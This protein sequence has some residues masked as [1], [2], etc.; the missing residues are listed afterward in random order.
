MGWQISKAKSLQSL[1]KNKNW[2]HI[3]G[4]PV[5]FKSIRWEATTGPQLPCLL[6]NRRSLK[7][8]I[9][10]NTYDETSTSSQNF[11]AY[12]SVYCIQFARRPVLQEMVSTA[13]TL[14]TLS[15][16]GRKHNSEVL[17]NLCLPEIPS[18]LHINFICI[19]CTFYFQCDSALPCTCPSFKPCQCCLNQALL[20]SQ[21]LRLQK[22]QNL[23][24]SNVWNSLMKGV[25]WS[26]GDAAKS[27][28]IK[29]S[30]Q[31]RAH[32]I[33]FTT[34]IFANEWSALPWS[35]WNELWVNP[36]M[37]ASPWKGTKLIYFYLGLSL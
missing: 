23:L 20:T 1:K 14:M 5:L 26:V 8:F 18:H 7:S 3:G 4:N 22:R 6:G 16:S 10:K 2:A 24:P 27:C 30:V 13:T 28:K 31:H 21:L 9:P 12:N 17:Q 33:H 29:K 19:C 32:G 15:Q 37:R 35:D 34:T 25:T 11:F 36:S